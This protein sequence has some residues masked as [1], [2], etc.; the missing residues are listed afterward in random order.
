MV[1]LPSLLNLRTSI[2]LAW[3][4]C[5]SWFELYDVATNVDS[6]KAVSEFGKIWWTESI[7]WASGNDLKVAAKAALISSKPNRI[8]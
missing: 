6:L 8:I 5:F 4:L 2:I 3:T 7:H 1:I